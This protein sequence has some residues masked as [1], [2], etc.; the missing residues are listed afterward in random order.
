[1]KPSNLILAALFGV[2]ACELPPESI[3]KLTLDP[4]DDDG[5]DGS[6]V[7]D[8]G[9]E[10]EVGSGG[11]EY[12]S[13]VSTTSDGEFCPGGDG[14]EAG[15]SETECEF[16]Y[17]CGD[18]EY[19]LDCVDGICTCSYNGEEIAECELTSQCEHIDEDYTSFVNRSDVLA[20]CGWDPPQ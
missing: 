16:E 11:D 1:M 12:S 5:G 18:Q 2:A 6:E 17:L 3:G 14:G 4:S 15:G 9:E 19:A 10:S 8:S 13:T 20:C 7:E